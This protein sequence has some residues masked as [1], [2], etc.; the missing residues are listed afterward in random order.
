MS[1]FDRLLGSV[2]KPTG[3]PEAP[4]VPPAAP[5]ERRQ[6]KRV[7]ARKG[8]TVLIIDDS[9]TVVA[10]LRKA[11]RSAGY[12]TREA[13]DAE[14]GLALI[15]EEAPEL[16]FLDIILPG[17]NGFNAL[18]AIRKLPASQ[19][20]PVIMISGNEH[21]TEQFYA[22]RIGADDFMKK[23]FSRHEIFARIEALL[24]EQFVP[25]RKVDAAPT[26]SPTAAAPATPTAP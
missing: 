9:P 10:V 26:S 20:I 24:D 12:D 22:N 15:A 4:A 7:N 5:V 3:K 19:H 21:A 1:I 16:I 23:P 18:R 17:M 25:R 11:L 14:Q 8:T 2:R 6:R 13:L